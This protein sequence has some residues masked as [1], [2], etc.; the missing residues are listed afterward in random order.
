MCAMTSSSDE[1]ETLYEKQKLLNSRKKARTKHKSS[2]LVD[3]GSEPR[4][5]GDEFDGTG[6]DKTSVSLLGRRSSEEDIL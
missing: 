2:V 3:I 4:R 6:L 5:S 1:D